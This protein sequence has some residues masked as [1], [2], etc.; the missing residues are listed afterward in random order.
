MEAGRCPHTGMVVYQVLQVG[1]Y[2]QSNES[3]ELIT[4]GLPKSLLLEAPEDGAYIDIPVS[5]Q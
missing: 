5:E 2:L 3:C 1:V 4:K